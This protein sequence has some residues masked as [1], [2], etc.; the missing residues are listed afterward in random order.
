MCWLKIPCG[1]TTISKI[2]LLTSIKTFVDSTHSSFFQSHVYR[3]QFY[4]SSIL[5]KLGCTNTKKKKK[6]FSL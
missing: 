5:G 6:V 3:V 2:L 1:L 4:Y